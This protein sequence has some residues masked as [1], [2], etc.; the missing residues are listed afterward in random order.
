LLAPIVV[1]FPELVTSPVKLA[2]VVTVAAFP[3]I[4]KLATGVVEVTTN[5]AVPVSYR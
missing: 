1:A 4:L 2:F 3:P 5:G